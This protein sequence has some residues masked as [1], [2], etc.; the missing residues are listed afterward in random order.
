VSQSLFTAA[1]AASGRAVSYNFGTTPPT[2]QAA[3]TYTGGLVTF[4]ASN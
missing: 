3:G 4:T 1:P 2:T